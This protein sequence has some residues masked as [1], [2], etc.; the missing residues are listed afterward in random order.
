M[1]N[2]KTAVAV[3]TCLVFNEFF[4]WID[5]EMGFDNILTKAF[6]FI[7]VREFPIYPCSAAVIAMKSSMQRS[8]KKGISRVFSAGMGGVIGVIFLGIC[9]VFTQDVIKIILA[10]AGVILCIHLCNILGHCDSAE[11]SC[12]IF[13]IIL[14]TTGSN[15]PLIY[16]SQRIIDTALGICVALVVNRYLLSPS[17]IWRRRQ[18]KYDPLAYVSVR[19]LEE[20]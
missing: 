6:A 13:L 1:R 9:N 7:F 20:N 4:C 14:I 8:V 19:E 18:M 17:C 12:V 15:D 10:T 5:S 3:C 11:N 2:I 16:A